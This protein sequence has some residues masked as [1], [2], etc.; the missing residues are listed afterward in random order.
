MSVDVVESTVFDLS[1]A[2]R[3][4]VPLAVF[5]FDIRVRNNSLSRP[6]GSLQVSFLNDNSIYR[7]LTVGMVSDVR[8]A[9]SGCQTNPSLVFFRDAFRKS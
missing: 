4:F 6:R 3:M 5:K 8:C 2:D 9:L 1:M 7:I